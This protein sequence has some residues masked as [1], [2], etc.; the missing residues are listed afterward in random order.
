MR[1]REGRLSA[2]IEDARN[3]PIEIWW[4]PDVRLHLKRWN[5]LFWL[6]HLWLNAEWRYQPDSFD[7]QD[8]ESRFG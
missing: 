5:P 8:A 7:R 4:T 1:L 2:F 3:P 6:V